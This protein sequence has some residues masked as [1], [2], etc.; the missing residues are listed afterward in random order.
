LV[1]VNRSIRSGCGNVDNLDKLKK[2]EF[3][4][5]HI[6]NYSLREGFSLTGWVWITCG[7][8]S[9]DRKTNFFPVFFAEVALFI[10]N[11]LLIVVINFIL[12]VPGGIMTNV[13]AG[14]ILLLV[15]LVIFIIA[16]R[17][18]NKKKFSEPLRQ[19]ETILEDFGN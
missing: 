14:V 16:I 19:L 10:L 5:L 15:W 7:Q 3:S 17:I 4:A 9:L 18:E 1:N 13:A 11:C 8:T 2:E 12:F 6:K